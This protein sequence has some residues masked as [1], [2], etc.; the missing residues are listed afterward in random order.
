MRKNHDKRHGRREDNY[1]VIY[2]EWPNLWSVKRLIARPLKAIYINRCAALW[3]QDKDF[4][5][6]TALENFCAHWGI[7]L[8]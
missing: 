6:V 2:V 4:A 1:D 5:N 8:L 3:A 7:K